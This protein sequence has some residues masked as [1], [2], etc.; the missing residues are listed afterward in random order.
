MLGTS[1][2]SHALR[3]D[4]SAAFAL[5]GR[6]CQDLCTVLSTQSWT[7]KPLPSP[8]KQLTGGGGYGKGHEQARKEHS[9]GWGGQ[10][11]LLEEGTR[12]RL[13][14]GKSK[15]KVFSGR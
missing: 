13:H 4:S 3:C 2:Q 1:P 10:G 5:T 6:A 15:R 14:Q 11:R 12:V 8:H 9:T 7:A